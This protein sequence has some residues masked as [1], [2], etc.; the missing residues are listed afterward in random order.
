[1]FP[2]SMK[3]WDD[4]MLVTASLHR[5][6][7]ILRRGTEVLRINGRAFPRIVD[8]LFDYISTDGYNTTHKY[9][10]LSNRGF[11]GSLYTSLFGLS[12]RYAIE[13]RD[14]MGQVK[15]ISVPAYNPA[16]D[17]ANRVFV[18]PGRPRITQPQPSKRERRRQQANTVRLLKID[19][20]NRTA[21]M[22]LS[23]FGRGYGLK[24]FFRNS[25]R[26]LRE[27]GSGT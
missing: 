3:V 10:T 16:T 22:D 24:K 11:F 9:Q 4:A 27:N 20:L 14:S 5:R 13:Y 6:D 12:E 7:S 26:T 2:L 18:R 19:T 23:S 15:T 25:F 1:M 8:T 17:T 21:M